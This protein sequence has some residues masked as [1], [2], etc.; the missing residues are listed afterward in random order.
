MKRRK[1]IAVMIAGLGL[2]TVVPLVANAAPVLIGGSSDGI[3]YHV[4]PATGLA[5]NPRDT[6]LGQLTGLAFAPDAVLYG[7]TGGLASAPNSL[8]IIERGTGSPQLVGAIGE[9]SFDFDF[10]PTTSLLYGASP[11]LG[12][13]GSR[14]HTIDPQSLAVNIIGSI[15]GT[16]ASVAINLSGRLYSL[17]SQ[18]DV[19]RE[20]DKTSGAT[21]A[22]F[23][24]AV[25]FRSAGV[26]FAP[27]G[28]LFV[29][30]GGPGAT[31]DFY[32]FDIST[33]TLTNVGPTGLEQGLTSLAFIP[34]PTT[35]T[36]LG[37]LACALTVSKEM[38][39]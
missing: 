37:V 29:V 26:A 18:G 21:L 8:F 33:G 10:D 25:N 30:D 2:S 27:D 13:G 15:D 5:S 22:S 34:E 1:T 16:T 31:N 39:R 4:D 7:R 36:L 24:L 11:I 32:T 12:A 3:I 19:L 20:I 17:A 14:L 6:G 9:F 23:P 35:L 28:T 38:V